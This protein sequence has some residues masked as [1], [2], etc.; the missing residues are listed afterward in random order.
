MKKK[1]F[2]SLLTAIVFVLAACGAGIAAPPATTEGFS[3]PTE[4]SVTTEV[5]TPG[6]AAFSYEDLKFTDFLYSSGAGAWGTTLYIAADG[7]FSG[8]YQDS[9][10]GD[11]GEGYPYGTVYYSDFYGQLGQPIPVN[12]YTYQLPI[13]VLRYGHAPDTQQIIDQQRYCYTTALGVEGTLELTLYL[14]GTP[15]ADL[16]ME[17]RQWLDP[18]IRDQSQLPFWGIYNEAQECSFTSSNRIENVRE[19][20]RIAEELEVSLNNQLTANSAQSDMNIVAQQRFLVWDDVLN[21]L[22]AVLRQSLEPRA[23]SRLTQ[24]QLAWIAEKDQAVADAA[25]EFEGAS[26]SPLVCNDLAANMTK[27]R[28]YILLDYLPG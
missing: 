2:V 15:V 4:P 25:A 5:T 6:E 17:Y 8:I 21:D 27:E 20:I 11:Q 12:A 14:P 16:P 1:I 13:Q 22:W 28:V 9:E 26:L 10:M 23:L 24:Q 18:F 7:T 3:A 19:R